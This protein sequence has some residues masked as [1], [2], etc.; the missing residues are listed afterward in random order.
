MDT[1]SY[2]LHKQKVFGVFDDFKSVKGVLRT[3]SVWTTGLIQFPPSVDGRRG[4]GEV[5]HSPDNNCR[6]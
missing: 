3:K 6:A 2:N 5:N 4:S 1:N